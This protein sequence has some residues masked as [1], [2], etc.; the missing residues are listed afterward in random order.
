[1]S[2]LTARLL[3]VSA[4][5]QD[6]L[7]EHFVKSA[8]ISIARTHPLLSGL[9]SDLRLL[10]E[11]SPTQPSDRLSRLGYLCLFLSVVAQLL[12]LVLVLRALGFIA[13]IEAATIA[14]N[15]AL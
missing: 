10:C 12:Y 13:P 15:T 11:V 5:S 4:S 1:L 7:V 2:P 8:S 14:P 9:W 6:S 3:I